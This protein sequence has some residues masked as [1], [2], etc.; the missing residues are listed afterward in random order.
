[1]TRNP[2]LV[3]G[4]GPTGMHTALLLAEAGHDVKIVSRRG[5]P[6]RSASPF[7][8]MEPSAAGASRV[9]NSVSTSLP[10]RWWSASVPPTAMT[11]SSGCG[12]T[13]RTRCFSTARS[14]TGVPCVTR[15]MRRRKRV[16]VRSKTLS[17]NVARCMNRPRPQPTYRGATF[18]A[19]PGARAARRK[20]PFVGNA[21]VDDE[22][23]DPQNEIWLSSCA[24]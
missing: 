24:S 17:R 3:I 5:R 12:A 11:S 20:P 2:K 10:A 13:T 7:R 4:A 23:L 21:P 1:M 18:L 14:F 16:A 8:T 22:A 9:T 19:R 15:W 6:A